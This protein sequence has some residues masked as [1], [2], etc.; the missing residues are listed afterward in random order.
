MTPRRSGVNTSVDTAER[1]CSAARSTAPFS[2]AR[3][4]SPGRI[5]SSISSCTSPRRPVTAARAPS[6]PNRTSCTSVRVRGEKPCVATWIAS[7][8]FVFPTP[9]GPTASTSPGRTARSS[10]SYDRKLR[11]LTLSTMRLCPWG[12]LSA[13]QT[14]RHDEVREIPVRSLEHRRAQRAD[15]LELHVVAL[16]CVDSVAEKLGVEADLERVSDER[17]RHRLARLADLLRPRDNRQLALGEAEV[18]RCRALDHHAGAADNVEEF[19]PRNRQLVLERLGQELA[20]VRELAVDAARRE[21]D[22]PGREDDLVLL[23]ADADLVDIA[24]DAR[25]LLQRAARDDRLEIRGGAAERRLLD[26]K[27][28]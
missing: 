22:V 8:R 27:A 12:R 14:D 23:H 15:V 21:P 26:R 2:R 7:R 16:D 1:S 17:H 20:D 11:R 6:S 4:P 24:G 19:E 28:I 10:R 18:E 13:G 3:F 25:K 5:V 9:F